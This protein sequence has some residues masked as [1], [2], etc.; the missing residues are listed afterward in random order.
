MFVS[1]QGQ[2]TTVLNVTITTDD[3]TNPTLSYILKEGDIKNIGF[4]KDKQL[5]NIKGKIKKI[6]SIT[7]EGDFYLVIDASGQ[8]DSENYNIKLSDV[9]TITEDSPQVNP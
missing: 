9:R 3:T 4:I 7:D 8:Y 6:I 5:I 1:I 2:P